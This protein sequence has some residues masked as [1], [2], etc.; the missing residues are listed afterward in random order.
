MYILLLTGFVSLYPNP[1]PE[2]RRCR[3]VHQYAHNERYDPL[4]NHLRG[5]HEETPS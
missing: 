2:T 3:R 5:V 1:P 4:Y